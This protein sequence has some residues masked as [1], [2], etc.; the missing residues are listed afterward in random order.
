MSVFFG[1]D[2]R[3]FELKNKLVEYLQE[4]NIRVEDL[5][6]YEYD[7]EDDFSDF[8]Q[9][10]VE[11]LLQTQNSQGILICGSGIGMCVAANRYKGVRCA[12]GFDLEEIRH[13][14]E[15]DHIN[16]LALPSDYIDFEK[17]KTFIDAFLE[18][19]Q[20]KDEKYLR[21]SN[22]LDDLPK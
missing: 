3:G 11:A 2:H 6:N 12:L 5:G 7:S 20:K 1:A 17:A 13:G 18:T 21:R 4:K 10:V 9:K 14:R 16:M 22:K 15:N 19:K 8:A